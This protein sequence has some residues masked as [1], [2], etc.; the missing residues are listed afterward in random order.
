MCMTNAVHTR[1]KT[2]ADERHLAC[3]A[4]NKMCRL[5]TTAVDCCWH[6][7]KRLHKNDAGVVLGFEKN[8]GIE[9]LP[10]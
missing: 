9:F 1:E 7:L 10:K 5:L 3:N 4:E 2:S 8:R 6:I